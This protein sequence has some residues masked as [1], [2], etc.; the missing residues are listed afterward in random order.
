[1]RDFK[2]INFKFPHL[3]IMLEILFSHIRGRHEGRGVA[4]GLVGLELARG[5]NCLSSMLQPPQGG[6]HPRED[7]ERA[8]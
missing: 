2:I 3:E 8:A 4:S 1:M 7:A 6:D 5:I